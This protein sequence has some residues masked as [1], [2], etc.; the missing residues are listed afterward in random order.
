MTL[1]RIYNGTAPVQFPPEGGINAMS[2]GREWR[3]CLPT[4][5]AI[6]STQPTSSRAS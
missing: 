3:M 4:R 2:Y 5:R 1:Y 6:G